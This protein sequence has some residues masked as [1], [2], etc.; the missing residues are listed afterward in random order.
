MRDSKIF[1]CDGRNIC[2]LIIKEVYK[3]IESLT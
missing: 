3:D 1:L 2:N